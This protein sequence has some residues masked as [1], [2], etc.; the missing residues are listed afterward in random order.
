MN[1][2]RAE[3]IKR[4]SLTDEVVKKIAEEISSGVLKR[5]EKLGS[6]A[7]WCERLQVSRS[8]FREALKVLQ[9]LGLIDIIVGKGAFISREKARKEAG[10]GAYP[11]IK[12]DVSRRFHDFM[13]ARRIIEVGIIRYAVQM[14]T[15][16]TISELETIHEA[17]EKAIAAKDIVRLMMLDEAFHWT[18]AQSSGNSLMIPILKN[19]NDQMRHY[20]AESFQDETIFRNSL[21]PHSLILRHFASRDIEGCKEAM[22]NHLIRVEFDIQEMLAK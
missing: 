16:D 15:A 8:T 2:K 5:G 13:Q 4:V 12:A 6:D 21:L 7:Y 18:I 19:L 3:P 11:E 9:A 22:E 1:S 10:G 14:A 17:F 20:R